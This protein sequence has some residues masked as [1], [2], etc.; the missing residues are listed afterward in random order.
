MLCQ[1]TLKRINRE[2]KDLK[3]EDLGGMTLEPSDDNMFIWKV[4]CISCQCSCARNIH[5]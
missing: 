3:L 5:R 1:M 4:R 2:I